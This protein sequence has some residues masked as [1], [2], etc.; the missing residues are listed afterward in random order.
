MR[1]E[2]S[3]LRKKEITFHQK[4]RKS[5]TRQKKLQTEPSCL[6]PAPKNGSGTIT[7]Q[8]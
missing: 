3:T 4:H 6:T 2:V 8:Q 7:M 1:F 5:T